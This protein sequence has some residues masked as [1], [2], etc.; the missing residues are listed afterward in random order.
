MT[1]E[2]EDAL[3]KYT[4][5]I[6]A[7]IALKTNNKEIFDLFNSL[8]L[9]KVEAETY[10][11]R[12]AAQ[13]NENIENKQIKVRVSPAFKKWFDYNTI[14]KLAKPSELAIINERA[15]ITEIDKVVFEEL[16]ETGKIRPELKQKS[17]RETPLTP[18]VTIKIKNSN[19]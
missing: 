2:Y 10:L 4:K 5:V 7:I 8:D 3:R 13:A 15:T 19:A 6:G 1:K 14:L 17:F 11:K 9:E 18:R 12:T 16:V